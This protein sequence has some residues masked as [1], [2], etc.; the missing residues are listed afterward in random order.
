MDFLFFLISFIASVV[1]AICGIGGGIIIKPSLDLFQMAGV[2]TISFLSGCTVLSMSLYSVVRAKVSKTSRINLKTATPMAIG[3]A[4]GGILGKQLFSLARQAFDNDAAVGTV[5]A[6]C[7]ALMTIGTLIYTLNRSR[8][9]THHMSHLLSCTAIGI[10]LGIIASFLGIGGGPIN[11]VVL[12][13]FFSMDI[14]AAAQN[15]LYIILFSQLTSLVMTL[16]TGTIPAFS[17]LSLVLMV[18]GGLLG[19]MFGRFL[20]MRMDSLAVERLFM[21]LMILIIV[22]SGYNAYQYAIVV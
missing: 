14:K 6:V 12:Y 11:L 2:P 8:I 3:G 15:S 22:I 17:W 19:G 1:G 21:I 16:L 13:F 18:I 4:I 10:G 20:Y 9:K 7:L 5:Q